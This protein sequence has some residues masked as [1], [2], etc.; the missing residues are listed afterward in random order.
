MVE[1]HSNRSLSEPIEL[2]VRDEMI[3]LGRFIGLRG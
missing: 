2:I 3:E 1:N